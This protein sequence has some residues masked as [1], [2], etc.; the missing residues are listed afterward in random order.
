MKGF[1]MDA[2][3]L[4]VLKG[5]ST[6]ILF[7]IWFLYHK[8]TTEQLSKIIDLQLTRE[9]ENFSLLKDM[10]AS[11]LLQN[12]KLEQVKSLIINNRWCP[13]YRRYLKE[14]AIFDEPDDNAA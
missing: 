9:K 4:N 5:S 13:V 10:I 7:V 3:L 14:G 6:L 12:E 2:A 8:S 11:N 1:L